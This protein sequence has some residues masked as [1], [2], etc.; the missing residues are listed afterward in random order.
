M[1]DSSV[2]AAIARHIE[3]LEV[4][5][6]HATNVMDRALGREAERIIQRKIKA[7]G[8]AGEVDEALDPVSWLAPN[9]WRTAGGTDDAFDL[10]INFE[11]TDCIDGQS[12]ETWVA[13][14][15]GFAGAGM[16]FVFGTNA[17]GRAKWKALLRDQ[18]DLID[19]LIDLGFHCDARAG[20][21]GLPVRIDKT[22][23]I[24]GFEDGDLADALLPIE[25]A[26]D[27]IHAAQPRFDR[28]VNAIRSKT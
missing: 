12:P 20:H 7:F 28:L 22:A 18:T 5:L 24:I 1:H 6:R 15:L 21:L 23:L 4:A 13:Q 25:T 16:Q 11:G 2:S 26:L 19:G 27:R 17:L 10:Y 14:F 9:S 8:W 3:E